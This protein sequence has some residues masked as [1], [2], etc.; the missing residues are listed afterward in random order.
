MVVAASAEAAVRNVAAGRVD[1]ICT[2]AEA[3]DAHSTAAH[4]TVHRCWEESATAES[5]DMRADSLGVGGEGAG[6]CSQLP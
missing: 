4:G 1:A 6:H 3:G 5:G 2:A